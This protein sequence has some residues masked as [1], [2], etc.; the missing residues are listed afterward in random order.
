MELILNPSYTDDQGIRVTSLAWETIIYRIIQSGLNKLA[1][2]TAACHL[3]FRNVTQ[4][5]KHLELNARLTTTD[6]WQSILIET[7]WTYWKASRFCESELNLIIFVL[8]ESKAN[9]IYS[10]EGLTSEQALFSFR[11]VKHSGGKG[12]TKNRAWYNSCVKQ[13]SYR[14]YY[15]LCTCNYVCLPFNY[16]CLLFNYACLS[17]NY[18]SLSFNY[19]CLSFNYVRFMSF[20][21]YF[22]S[23]SHGCLS[24]NYYFLSCNYVFLHVMQLWLVA[25]QLQCR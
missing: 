18:V 6:M 24:F 19:A 23:C 2:L 17:F 21:H 25:I 22:L 3:N 14:K 11:A 9:D 12:K 20:N 15:L 13:F 8:F 5:L 7:F 1:W 10:A 4:R 16:A